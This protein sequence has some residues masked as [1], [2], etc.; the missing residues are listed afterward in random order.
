MQTPEQVQIDAE[1]CRLKFEEGL[2]FKGI[3]ERMGCSPG[4][5]HGRV[6]R[7]L[8]LMAGPAPEQLRQQEIAKLDL[9][10]QA[11]WKVLEDRHLRVDHGRVVTDD[12][13]PIEDDAPVLAAIDRV[14]KIQDRRAKLVGLDAPTKVRH[15]VITEDATDAAIRQLEAE[16]ARRSPAG[17]TDLPAG[18]SAP[19]S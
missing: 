17:E 2:S 10:E 9:L 4:A 12:G 6:N 8:R 14:L 1:A 13:V 5:A 18:T 16:L 19:A 7:A 15:E 11:A 3:A